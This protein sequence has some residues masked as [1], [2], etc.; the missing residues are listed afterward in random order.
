[1]SDFTRIEDST[2]SIVKKG[3]SGFLKSLRWLLVLLLLA[4]GVF[5][6]WKYFY[7]YSDGN[8]SGLLQKLS[9]KGNIFKT[10]EGEL[11]QRSIVSTTNVGIASEKFYF[12]VVNDSIAAKMGDFEGKN[13]KLHYLQKNGKLPWRGE[14]EYIV[15]GVE[16]DSNP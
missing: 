13:V 1:M 10:Y 14:S 4:L 3:A 16:L 2:T 9:H 15:D 7:T 12:S 6:Y 5:I 8:R 11:V